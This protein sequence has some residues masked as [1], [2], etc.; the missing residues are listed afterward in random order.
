MKDKSKSKARFLRDPIPR[1][2][3][4]IAA[5]LARIAS[6]ARKEAG[7]PRVLEMIKEVKYYIEWTAAELDP[8]LAED[9]VNMQI[10]LAFWQS[11][12]VNMDPNSRQ[13]HML[14]FQAKVWSDRVL[15]ASGLLG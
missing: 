8:E 5:S 12:W 7:N 3:G 2:L 15:Q 4:S 10:A 14:S 1:R 13:R 9:L 6:S 11:N